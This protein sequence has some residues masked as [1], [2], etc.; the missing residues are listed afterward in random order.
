MPFVPIHHRSHPHPTSS[1]PYST[2]PPP[3]CCPP[4]STLP[5]S[6]THILSSP[7]PLHSLT[8]TPTPTALTHAHP[9]PH[10]HFTHPSFPL[11]DPIYSPPPTSTL[12]MN[13]SLSSTPSSLPLLPPIPSQQAEFSS[14]TTPVTTLSIA[15]LELLSRRARVLKQLCNRSAE[16]L[17]SLAAAAAALHAEERLPSVAALL[18]DAGPLLYELLTA[19]QTPHTPAP[20]LY[21]LQALCTAAEDA[22]AHL[23]SC[24]GELMAA[25]FTDPPPHGM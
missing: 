1:T 5:P 7:H 11:L 12:L 23:R 3:T 15:Q 19:A 4:T 25:V 21:H 8:H 13:F 22:A 17:A 2:H 24:H 16:P 10:L 18:L 6:S 20:V 14:Q 9:L